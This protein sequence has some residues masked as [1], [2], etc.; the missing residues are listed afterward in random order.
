MS[1]PTQANSARVGLL[2][3]S[4]DPIHTAHVRLAR[5]ARDELKLDAVWLVPAGQPWQRDPLAA[6][7]SDRRAMVEL[8]IAGHPGLALCDIE[9]RRQGPSYT[10]DTLR[11]LQSAH[12]RTA[13]TFIVGA[14]QLGNLLTWNGW[15]EIAARVDIAF[16]RRPG[17]ADTP[18]PALLA[19]LAAHGRQLHRLDM[20]AID[21]SAT[22]VR[23]RL[24]HREPLGDL[25]PAPVARYIEQH[26]L[27]SA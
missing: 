24:A 18:P 27:Y 19:A 13:F 1:E 3:G 16:A 2:G 5:A 6:S 23:D 4:F 7:P 10:V 9:L 22:C 21:L 11:E 20:P 25:V 14:D 8:A 26:R 17:H 12:P 15:E